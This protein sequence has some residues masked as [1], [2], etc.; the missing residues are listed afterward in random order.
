[1][2]T[3]TLPRAASATRFRAAFAVV[4]IALQVLFYASFLKRADIN[5]SDFPTYYSVARLWQRGENP[6]LLEHQCKEMQ[7][8]TPQGDCFPLAHPPVFLPFL[9]AVTSEN[10]TAS[11]WRWIVV[12]VVLLLLCVFPLYYLSRDLAV[13]FQCI[14][15]YATVLAVFYGNDVPFVLL[16]VCLWAWLTLKGDEDFLAGW[17]LAL[18]VVKPQFALIL[19]IPLLFSR[20]AVF[21][22]FCEGAL[23]AVIVSLLLVGTHGFEGIIEIT[24]VMAE[25]GGYGIG[26]VNMIN[27]TGIVTRMGLSPFWSWPLYSLAIGGLCV[28]WRKYGLTRET[29]SVGIVCAL[30]FAPHSHQY[31]MALLAIP[32]LFA[33]RLAP[34]VGSLVMILTI[35]FGVGYYGAFV[36]FAGIVASVWAKSRS[37]IPRTVPSSIRNEP[38]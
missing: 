5:T 36:L 18:A 10:F 7:S 34:L 32:L 22:G 3:T 28:L 33:H 11:F 31:D 26:Q 27:L 29:I 23:I 2:S 21:V 15:L 8:L 35:P 12:L 9:V 30:F 20:R 24:R 38:S 17:A 6:Y 16:G 37:A 4:V 1:V 19:A 14:L 13:A 25:G